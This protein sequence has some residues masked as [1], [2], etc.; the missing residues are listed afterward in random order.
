MPLRMK[1]RR[2]LTFHVF[3]PET[4]CFFLKADLLKKWAKIPDDWKHWSR[5]WAFS[6]FLFIQSFTLEWENFWRE[7]GNL[8]GERENFWRESGNLLGERE[9]FWRESGNLL[10][11]W[12][13]FWRESGNLR[14]T[15]KTAE[16]RKGNSLRGM[17]KL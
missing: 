3:F 9:N 8:L 7:S 1:F 14:G 5:I 17:G 10:R 2:F 15:G 12:E 4:L 13:N 16:G 11:E 6:F